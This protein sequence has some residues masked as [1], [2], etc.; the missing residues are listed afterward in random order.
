MMP[1]DIS[2]HATRSER[3]LLCYPLTV[4]LL[5]VVWAICVRTQIERGRVTIA[6]MFGL[7]TLIAVGLFIARYV[8]STP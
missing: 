8:L 5:S 4:V 7:V 6:A 3:R 1:N 2:Y